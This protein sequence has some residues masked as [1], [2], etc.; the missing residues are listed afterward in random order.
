[1][2]DAEIKRYIDRQIALLKREMIAMIRRILRQP[3]S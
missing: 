2:T 1:M 3:E